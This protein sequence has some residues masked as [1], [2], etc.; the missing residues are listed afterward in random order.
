MLIE[1]RTLLSGLIPKIV[2]RVQDFVSQEFKEGAV[3]VFAAFFGDN[4]DVGSS[5]SAKGGVVKAGL[6]F[7]LLYGVGVR[8]RHASADGSRTQNVAN[9]NP[10]YLPFVVVR[11]RSVSVN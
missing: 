3:E 11:S 10:I 4:T 6:Y 7:K 9:A 5:A 8:D 1:F 2:I